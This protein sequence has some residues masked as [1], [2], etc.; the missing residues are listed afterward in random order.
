MVASSTPHLWLNGNLINLKAVRE[1]CPKFT[2][3]GSSPTTWAY[4]LSYRGRR[5][6]SVVPSHECEKRRCRCSQRWPSWRW[7]P[8]RIAE[9]WTK[10][11][12]SYTLN[13]H[14]FQRKRNVHVAKYKGYILYTIKKVKKVILEKIVKHV[15]TH[16]YNMQSLHSGSKP[17][18]VST[19]LN[20]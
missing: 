12:N 6:S 10:G 3:T 13:Q 2:W 7:E 9:I 20:I 19:V 14:L 4:L 5:L 11:N 1:G 15:V 8:R 17:K 18:R 16:F